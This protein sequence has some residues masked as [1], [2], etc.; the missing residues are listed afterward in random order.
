MKNKEHKMKEDLF[1]KKQVKKRIIF[2]YNF[3]NA[4]VISLIRKFIITKRMI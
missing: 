2:K 3:T 4:V 1:I